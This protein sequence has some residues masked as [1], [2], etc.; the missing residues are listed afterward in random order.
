M[1]RKL[2]DVEVF[3]VDAVDEGLSDKEKQ[4]RID[5]MTDELACRLAAVTRVEVSGDGVEIRYYSKR[6]G[7][8][9]RVVLEML[10]ASGE[11]VRIF[12]SYREAGEYFGVACHHC[13][14]AARKNGYVLRRRPVNTTNKR[15]TKTNKHNEKRKSTNKNRDAQ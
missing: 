8:H 13:E 14:T 15:K 1:N 7:G 5:Q 10:N 3:T 11:V 2:K 12:S 6:N 9:N 4:M